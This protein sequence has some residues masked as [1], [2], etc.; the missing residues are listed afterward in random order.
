MKKSGKLQLLSWS[1]LLLLPL[2][3]YLFLKVKKVLNPSQRI[4]NQAN[5]LGFDDNQSKLILAQSKHETGNFT[6]PL[7]IINCN[8]FGMRPA[9][10]RQAEQLNYKSNDA[11]AKYDSIEQSVRDLA[12][13]MQAVNFIWYDTPEAYCAELQKH[14]YFTDSLENYTNNVKYYYNG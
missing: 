11:Y 5:L 4:I 1:W 7:F 14:G 10:E 8:C 6:S 12:L 9:Q 13:W 3:V 2:V